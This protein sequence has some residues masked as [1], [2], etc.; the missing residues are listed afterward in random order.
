MSLRVEQ[1]YIGSSEREFSVGGAEEGALNLRA[2]EL[3]LGQPGSESHH[4]DDKVG[5]TLDLLPKSFASGA[6][7][8]FFDAIDNAGKWEWGLAVGE[9]GSE[10]DL[11]K[12]GCLL[13]TSGQ[14]SEQGNVGKVAAH[15]GG[16]IGR[17]R[18]VAPAAKF[19]ITLLLQNTFTGICYVIQ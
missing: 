16:S 19:F 4:R 2:T 13:S 6:K 9:G 7:R 15:C 17:D 5:L 10:V 11:V 18:S 1:D 12:G 14:A 3:R 8:G